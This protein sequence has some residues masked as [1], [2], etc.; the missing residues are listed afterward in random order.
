MLAKESGVKLEV[1]HLKAIGKENEKNI[2]VMLEMIENY[3][4][5]G[6]DVKFDV[7]PYTFGSSSPSFLHVSSHIR[8]LNRG[9][10]FPWRAKEE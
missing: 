4:R 9:W 1:S 2:D 5:E 10:H 7:Y 8:V 6:V 3:R